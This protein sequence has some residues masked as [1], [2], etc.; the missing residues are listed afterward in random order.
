M[1]E[2]DDSGRSGLLQRARAATTTRIKY[3]VR[4]AKHRKGTIL[5][6]VM[7]SVLSAVAL[8]WAR[9]TDQYEGN[10]LLN[11]GASFVGAVVTYALINPMITRAESREEKILDHLEHANII[12]HIS[13]S[14]SIFRIFETGVE[15]LLHDQ[16]RYGFLTACRAA[17]NG[18]VRVEILLLDPDCR[19]AAQRADELGSALDLRSLISENL[20]YFH[21]FHADLNESMQPRFEVRVYVTSPLAAYYRW[22]RRA[23][24]SFFP[25]GR[26]SVDTTQYE[27]SVESNFAQFVEQ[28]FL[29]SWKAPSTYTLQEYFGLKVKIMRDGAEPRLL[30]A[31]WVVVDDRIY[32]A[33]QVLT[34]QALESGLDQLQV[35]LD[36][37]VP[38]V[39]PF[40]GA[41][42]MALCEAESPVQLA[43]DRKYGRGQRTIL[44]VCASAA[45]TAPEF[46]QHQR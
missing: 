12:Q 41:C 23:L 33:H 31:E 13:E 28:R 10:L 43:F 19:A 45:E 14:R 30:R 29:E 25:T 17:L 26:S 6:V 9:D 1:V 32:L 16:Y 21:E 36:D 39:K 18:G 7:L 3:M 27:T 4:L 2:G 5:A 40:A 42:G 38:H 8:Y 34:K 11:L 22:D 15:L 35:H 24:I 37:V 46:D 20:R 44:A